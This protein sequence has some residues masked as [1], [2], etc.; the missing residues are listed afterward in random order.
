MTKQTD[1]L[2][3]FHF[4]VK[5]ISKF[6]LYLTALLLSLVVKLIVRFFNVSPIDLWAIIDSI[7]RRYEIR[8]IN[9][10]I[11]QVPE[12]MSARIDRE[13]D[14]AIAMYNSM[15][16]LEKPTFIFTEVKE[17]E[18]PLGGEMRFRAPWIKDSEN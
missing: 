3:E 16:E 14:R 15:V 9:K 5:T 13:I 4:G 12:L 10:L 7:G 6:D 1:Y 17:G 18:T 8:V 11:L 2:V